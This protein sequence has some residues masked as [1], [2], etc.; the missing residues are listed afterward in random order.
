MKLL[1]EQSLQ[2]EET[3]MLR[4]RYYVRKSGSYWE[5]TS[6]ADEDSLYANGIPTE[7]L[8]RKLAHA[9]NNYIQAHM[10]LTPRA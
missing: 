7:E 9:V 6:E 10:P 4:G 2:R 8:A 3:S 5:I 1:L